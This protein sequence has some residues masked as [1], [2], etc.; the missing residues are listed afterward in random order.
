M[1]QVADP[2]AGDGQRTDKHVL[3]DDTAVA[4]DGK[5]RPSRIRS[6]SACLR[7]KTLMAESVNL[8]ENCTILAVLVFSGDT[9][10]TVGLDSGAATTS[11]TT[12]VFESSGVVDIL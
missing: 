11:A 8:P 2:A 1:K 10:S 3:A 12:G 6:R 4:D 9:G 5:V 7:V